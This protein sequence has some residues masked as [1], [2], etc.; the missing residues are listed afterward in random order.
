MGTRCDYHGICRLMSPRTVCLV[1]WL[2]AVGVGVGRAI[3]TLL[4]MSL[5]TVMANYC[6][7]NGSKLYCGLFPF[8][9]V[10]LLVFSLNMLT[11]TQKLQ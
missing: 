10:V 6:W 9:F 5:V 4:K 8:I 3:L 1:C 7:F 2:V 11:D